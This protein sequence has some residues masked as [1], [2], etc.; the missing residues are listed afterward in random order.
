MSGRR[1]AVLGGGGW[2]TALAQVTARAGNEVALWARDPAVVSAINTARRNPRYLSDLTLDPAVRATADLAAAI[3]AAEAVL[4]AV[5][6]QTVRGLA[7]A[8][9]ATG[10]APTT[11]VICAK[12][13]E[14][15]SGKLLSEVLDES[16][17]GWPV[18][19]LSGPSFAGE[20]AAGVPTAVTVAADSL[21]RAGDLA[22]CFGTPS[23]RPYA[24]DDV[25]G[26]EVAGAVKN[27]IAI[28]A[29]IAAGLGFGDNTRAAL[30]TRGLAEIARFAVALGGRAET[31]M[32]L[33]GVGDMVLTCA[34]MQSRN[35]QFGRAVGAGTAVATLRAPPAPVV[36]GVASAAA[37]VARARTA[38][39]DMPIAEAVDAVVNHGADLAATLERLLA[40]PLRPEDH[41]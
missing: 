3:T 40:R 28:A 4:L 41:R 16:L 10:V 24:S 5:P 20:T 30:I 17:P 33:A 25:I 34:S 9:A 21:A 7:A 27:V 26:V 2:G 37:V 35:T 19:V 15:G 11:V 22:A 1:V 13:L 12:G 38:G 8:L 39:V 6:A 29:G 23:F 18:A 32:G 31:V 36:E 14:I